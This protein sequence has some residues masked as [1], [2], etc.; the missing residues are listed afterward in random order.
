MRQEAGGAHS[1]QTVSSAFDVT[2]AWVR[3]GL[4]V[5]GLI[6]SLCN[7]SRGPTA[8]SQMSKSGV[9]FS[10]RALDSSPVRGV[11]ADEVA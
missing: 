8:N 6:L 10:S 5:S 1:T 9:R 2:V 3:L 11:V 7:F 4:G